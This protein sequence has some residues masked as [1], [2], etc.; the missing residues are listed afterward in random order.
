[1]KRGPLRCPEPFQRVSQSDGAPRPVTAEAVGWADLRRWCVLE[2][3]RVLA[4]DADADDAAQ[5]AVLR[6]WRH[7]G[8]CATPDA[9][10]AWVRRIAHRE[11]LRLGGRRS[12]TWRGAAELDEAEELAAPG[13]D[14]EVLDERLDVAEAVAELDEGDRRLLALRYGAD[15]TQPAVAEMLGIPEGTVKVRL[16][17][18]RRRLRET[19]A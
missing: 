8:T 16:H 11:A 9:P 14:P 4:D 5:E 1:M 3:G 10:Q 2:A 6:A 15:L 7:F 17:R 19:L 13:A 12:R 18:I